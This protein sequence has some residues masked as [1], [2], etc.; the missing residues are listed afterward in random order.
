MAN[1]KKPNA[2]AQYGPIGAPL[3]GVL[4]A[5]VFIA[6]AIVTNELGEG[7]TQLQ[8]SVEKVRKQ[9]DDPSAGGET[10]TIPLPDSVAAAMTPGEANNWNPPAGAGKLL[11]LPIKWVVTM[12]DAK[13]D[14]FDEYD[15]A[16]KDGVW[17][18]N[19]FQQTPI[20]GQ[21]NLRGEF[22]NWDRNSDGQISREEYDDPPR[23]NRE[24]FDELN[25]NTDG[26]EFLTEGEITA[27][28]VR[29]WDRYPYD[30]KVS[31][32]EFE[33]RYEPREERDLGPVVNV[34]AKVDPAQMEIIVTWE[35]PAVA[36]L[37]EDISFYIVRRAPETVEKRKAEYR[38]KVQ[39][40]NKR[41]LEWEARFDSWWTS[42][43]DANAEKTNKQVEPNK[44]KAQK[45]FQ[46]ATDDLKPQAP[47][48]AGDWETVTE[49]PITGNE[50]R[51]TSFDTD[52]TYTYAVYMATTKNPK[53][54]V[55]VGDQNAAG[56]YTWPERTLAS[57]HPVIVT[58]R[59]VMSAGGVS[60][61]DVSISLTKWHP[62]PDA[63][64]NPVWYKVRVTEKISPQDSLGG[65]Y[66]MMALKDR[67]VEMFDV[68]D[69]ALNAAELLPEDTEI[70]FTT[71]FNFVTRAGGFVLNSREHGDFELPTATRGAITNPTQPSTSDNA[72]EVRCLTVKNGGKE[73][74]IELTRW[75]KVG[76][77]W[78]RVV[79]TVNV[80]KGKDVG[81]TINLGSPGNDVKVFDA[82]GK[83]LKSSDLKKFADQTVD[84]AAGEYEGL[85]D[86][87]VTV[88][89]TTVD[90]FGTI[91]KD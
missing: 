23:D 81:G 54:G 53:R 84:L 90:L 25:T 39:D 26:G 45:K 59:I 16:P 38:R 17:T 75:H 56:Y 91:F 30:D 60:G 71:G 52:V 12:D 49:S 42:P 76:E 87:N 74:R 13:G 40:Y 50:Y 2:L 57:G 67:D 48:Q 89:G 69:T 55:N 22:K 18:E 14:E 83:E 80:G 21:P 19:E 58:N 10:D 35:N 70:D 62:V 61:D 46:E 65:K 73:A 72:L 86:R 82:T 44:N 37:P 7:Q 29:D 64:G 15:I 51:D 68:S 41:L 3:L 20:W 1:E 85:K 24:Q 79:M 77:D 32:E 36:D 43:S 27:Q 78:L 11:E 34:Q 5:I 6:I 31:F 66:N 8:T 28:Q 88:G 47:E 63:E 9:L 4:L 33:R